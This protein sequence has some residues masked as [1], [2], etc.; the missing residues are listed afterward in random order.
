MNIFR[1]I[2]QT[3]VKSFWLLFVCILIAFYLDKWLESEWPFLSKNFIV[4]LLTYL[5]L[6]VV[7]YYVAKTITYYYRKS[8]NREPNK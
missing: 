5:V 1:K 8:K 4:G 2:N 6:F 3:N 7:F